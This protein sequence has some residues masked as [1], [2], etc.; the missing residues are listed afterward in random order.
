[1]KGGKPATSI[2]LVSEYFFP[3][4]NAPGA[5]FKPI[6]DALISHDFDVSIYTSKISSNVKEYKVK[7]NKFKFPSNQKST[8]SRLSQELLFGI[9]TFIRLLFSRGHY[10]YITSPSFINCICAF[11]YCKLF[12]K[13]YIVDIRDDYPRVYF[14]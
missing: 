3:A 2:I 14:D 11:L 7:S 5:R 13:R 10:Y 4:N 8:L 12:N 1:M 6:V 9:E